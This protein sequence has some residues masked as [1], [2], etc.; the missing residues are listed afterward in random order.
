MRKAEL[1]CYGCGDAGHFEADC[2]HKGIDADG[3]PPWCGFC[4]ERTR[5]IDHGESVSRCQQ[6]HPNRRK[7][8]RQHRKC[9]LCHMTVYEWDNAPCGS[10]S[11]PEATDRRP[12]RESIEQIIGA[13][14]T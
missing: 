2:P 12:E 5:L 10:H 13:K 6:C 1:T 8:S 3:K 7:Q 9:P 4:D 11:G 14:G